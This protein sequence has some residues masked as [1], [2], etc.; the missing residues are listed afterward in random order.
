MSLKSWMKEF[1][2]VDASRVKGRKARIKHSLKK[3]RGA[4]P[5]N[6]DKH[7]V[8][9]WGYAVFDEKRELVFDADTCAL[10]EKYSQIGTAI[11]RT[12]CPRCPIVIATGSTCCKVYDACSDNPTEMIG[13]LELTL[14]VEKAR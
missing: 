1:Y 7:K 11:M 4:L 5:E 6:L 12:A 13:L 8:E 3:W 9:Y 10:C 14:A 2:P